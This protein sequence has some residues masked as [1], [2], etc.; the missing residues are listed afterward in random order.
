MRR[1]SSHIS[2]GSINQFQKPLAVRRVSFSPC[3]GA[4]M[5]LI[6]RARVAIRATLEG[7]QNFAV[8]R[9]VYYDRCKTRNAFGLFRHPARRSISFCL[10][11]IVK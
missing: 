7:G 8:R 9:V 3:L 10:A 4:I 2:L 6:P 5:R 1:L 11:I